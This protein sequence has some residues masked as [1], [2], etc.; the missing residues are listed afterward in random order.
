MES[1]H[2]KESKKITDSDLCSITLA[3]AWEDITNW[4][5]IAIIH[6]R[7][8]KVLCATIVA[9]DVVNSVEFFK[10]FED[11]VKGF[12]DEPDIDYEF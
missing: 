11:R 9:G 7:D 10:L 3:A 4:N 12:V 8:N 1:Y 5:T 6:A 2:W